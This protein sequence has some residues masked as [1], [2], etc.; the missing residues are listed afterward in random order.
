LNGTAIH[1]ITKFSDLSL[2]EFHRGFTNV[3][4]S[5]VEALRETTPLADIKVESRV[6]LKYNVDWT[7]VLTTPV[8]NQGY[9]GSCWAFSATSQI[10]SDAIRTIGWSNLAN[11]KL[12]TGQMVSCTFD[13]SGCK[14]GWPYQG[15]EGV[16]RLGGIEM[17]ATYP[18]ADQESACTPHPNKQVIAVTG[19]QRLPNDENSM[20]SFV[21]HTGPLSVCVFASTWNTYTGGV[22][23]DCPL[24]KRKGHCVQAVGV[25]TDSGNGFWKIRNSWVSIAID[26]YPMFFIHDGI[27]FMF[28][29]RVL[30][31]VKMVSFVWPGVAT[32]VRSTSTLP[33]LMFA[34]NKHV[35]AMPLHLLS[36][37]LLSLYVPLYSFSFP[38]ICC[39][40]I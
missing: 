28:V 11:Y 10:E 37:I 35:L 9:C 26:T 30:I 7:G 27:C 5:E 39:L 24:D 6:D 17:A 29:H 3:D 19:Y 34:G 32:H 14:G 13:R 4:M 38:N 2:E 1:G 12:S 33:I 23:Y 36:V 8:K 15:Y 20:A 40:R 22:L 31:G 16:Q 25:Y 18:Y 21:Q